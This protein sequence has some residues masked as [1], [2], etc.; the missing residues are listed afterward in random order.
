MNRVAIVN[1]QQLLAVIL[2][3]V[4]I[5]SC[6]S[7]PRSSSQSG[8]APH[9]SSTEAPRGSD[10]GLTIAQIAQAMVG[11]SYRYGGSNPDEGFDCSGLV[12]YS[13]LKVGEKIPRVSYAQLAASENVSMSD[14][15]PGD[16]LFYR[17]NG[18]PS[19]V[20]IYIG[21]GQFVH[22]PSSGKKV[23]VTSMANL[24]FKPRFIRAGRL[25][26]DN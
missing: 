17:I 1:I 21:Q 25:Y 19:H 24:Y 22:A 16:L 4:L 7:T 15:Q 2:L 9:R 11:V 14:L 26:S 8:S 6:A 3:A 12:Y 18:S 23:R 5:T 20:G 10:K 13:H